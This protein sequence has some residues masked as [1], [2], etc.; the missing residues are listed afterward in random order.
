MATG[1]ETAAASISERARQLACAALLALAVLSPGVA[2]AS[3]LVYVQQDGTVL[4]T[5]P[6]VGGKIVLRVNRGFP[7]VILGQEGEWLNVRSPQYAAP[8][9]TLWVPADRVGPAPEAT[10]QPASVA[11]PEP[12]EPE[13]TFWIYVDGTPALKFRAECRLVVTADPASRRHEVTDL[14]PAALGFD[15]DA[16]SCTVRKLDNF[17]DLIVTLT[18]GQGIVI[19]A[20]DTSALFGSVRVRSDGPWGVARARRGSS[21]VIVVRDFP[22]PELGIPKMGTPVPSFTGSPVP[23]LGSSP[24]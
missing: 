17:G 24:F 3:D 7:L 18:N 15:A 14:V 11:A 2:A 20:L 12:A 10:S 1:K 5:A 23:P 21:R 8:G 13:P 22:E 6:G 19:A 4:A 16:V 9:E